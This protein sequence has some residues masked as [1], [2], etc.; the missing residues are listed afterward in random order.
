M[1]TFDRL[2]TRTSHVMSWVALV[3][4]AFMMFAITID[5]VARALSGRA[6]PGLFEM[7]EMSMAMVVFMGLGVT[8]LDD[9]HIRVTL[10]TDRLPKVIGRQCTAV[11]WVFAGLTFALLAWPATKE[12]VYSV[13]ILEFRWGALQVPVWWA[14]VMVAVGL[15]FAVLQAFVHAALVAR[16]RLPEQR[17][18]NA[19]AAH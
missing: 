4:L 17:R 6:V 7:S 18:V 16:D 19:N 5:V 11:G 10:V 9:G 2:L 15:W 1:L 8:L 13:S 3:F 14:K 12:A